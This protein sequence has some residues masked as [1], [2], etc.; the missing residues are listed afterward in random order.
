[1]TR[2][3]IKKCIRE[4]QLAYPSYSKNFNQEDLLQLIE[5][6]E[7]QFN[8]IN[9]LQVFSALQEAISSSEFPPSIATIKK[10]I[11]KADDVNEEEIWRK[12]LNAGKNG[13]YGFYGEWEKLPSDLKAVTTPETIREIALADNDSLQFIKRDFL[14]NYQSHI[15]V[16]RDKLI[17]GSISKE[18][19]LDTQKEV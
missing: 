15:S 5:I 13:T 12:L 11:F 4:I 8:D 14:K 3:G 18:L 6:W 7:L 1:M 19:L 10:F 9:D 16:S 17:T 2:D